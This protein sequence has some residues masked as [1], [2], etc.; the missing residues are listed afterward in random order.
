MF[1]KLLA[2]LIFVLSFINCYASSHA[3]YIKGTVTINK[4]TLDKSKAIKVG[5]TISTFKDSLVLI[6]LDTGATIKINENS[7]LKISIHKPKTNT[8]LVQLIKGS[9]FFRK[10]PKIKGKFNVKTKV[11]TMGVRGT[12]FFV[13]YGQEL[14]DEVFMCVNKGSVWVS[15]D[16]KKATIVKEG[17]GVNITKKNVI[18]QPRFLPWTKDLNWSLNPKSKTLENDASIE[19]KY[20]DP[21]DQDYD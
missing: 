10:D 16:K 20:G 19:E 7:S 4:K 11:A 2:V 12:Q 21:L 17:E 8:T 3:L 1:I 6:Q 9:S 15:A 5:D 13:A 18:S 14:S